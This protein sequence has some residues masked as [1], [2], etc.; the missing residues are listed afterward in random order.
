MLEENDLK[1]NKPDKV[2]ALQK[3]HGRQNIVCRIRKA[4]Q[5]LGPQSNAHEQWRMNQWAEQEMKRPM[6]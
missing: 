6:R 2:S 4:K 5:K 3:M 1:Q